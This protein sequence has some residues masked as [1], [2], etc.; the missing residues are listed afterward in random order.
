MAVSI[1]VRIDCR[2]VQH[3]R[4]WDEQYMGHNKKLTLAIIS[5]VLLIS[6]YLN[7]RAASFAS[8]TRSESSSFFET[9]YFVVNTTSPPFDNVLVR[10][11]LAMATDRPAIT[12]ALREEKFMY[13]P[14]IGLVPAYAGYET[15]R[16]LDVVIDGKTYDVLS[17]DPKAARELLAKGGFPEGVGKNKKKL[18]IEVL[19][20]AGTDTQ[21]LIGIVGQQWQQNLGIDIVA[22]NR[23]WHDY[24]AEKSERNFKGVAVDGKALLLADA[25]NLLSFASGEVEKKPCWDDQKFHQMLR[26]ASKVA[27]SDATLGNSMFRECEAYLLRSMPVIPLYSRQP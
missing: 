8:Q 23:K 22:L 26:D 12:N 2:F 3:G 27:S 14:G 5:T 15:I 25:S 16:R 1:V 7:N 11:A 10:Y 20:Y 13:Y 18:V 9:I 19:I 17:Y 21:K 6:A 24:L 4:P